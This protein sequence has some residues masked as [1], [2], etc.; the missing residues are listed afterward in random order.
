VRTVY[1]AYW[2]IIAAGIVVWIAV[3]L[4]VE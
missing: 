3:G 2:L 1:T 4:T